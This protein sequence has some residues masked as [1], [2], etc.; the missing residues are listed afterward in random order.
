[1]KNKLIV[2][3]IVILTGKPKQTPKP[4]NTTANIVNTIVE[5]PDNNSDFEFTKDYKF[6]YDDSWTLNA[7]TSKKFLF[8]GLN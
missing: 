6:Y 3:A 2:A 8:F 4:K 1:M 7:E 5:E